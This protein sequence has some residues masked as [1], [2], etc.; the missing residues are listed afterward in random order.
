MMRFAFLPVVL[1]ALLTAVP[2][3]AATDIE[4]NAFPEFDIWIALD[5][6]RKMSLK[7]FPCLVTLLLVVF[8]VTPAESTEMSR[9]TNDPIKIYVT[10]FIIDVDDISGANQSFNANVHIQYRWQGGLLIRGRN[11][12][13]GRLMRSG[14]PRCRLSTSRGYG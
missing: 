8:G 14:T 10:I 5:K 4:A 13:S 12:S 1:L 7:V 6:E 3:Y 9:P 2:G 11:R